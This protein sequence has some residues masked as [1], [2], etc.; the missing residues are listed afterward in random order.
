MHCYLLDFSR[1]G[2]SKLVFFLLGDS[3]VSQ[4]H[5]L[6]RLFFPWMICFGALLKMNRSCSETIPSINDNNM[7]DCQL[8]GY[9]K[10]RCPFLL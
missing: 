2:G 8:V 9:L 3:Q 7:S 6:N 4:H 1:R 10:N 5:L